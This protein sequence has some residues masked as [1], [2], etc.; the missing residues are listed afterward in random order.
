M[1]KYYLN[2]LGVNNSLGGNP[3]EVLQAL[4]DQLPGTAEEFSLVSGRKTMTRPVKVVLPEIPSGFIEF[5]SRN[6][7][8]LLHAIEQ[9]RPDIVK[10]KQQYG[11]A[12]V[13][14]VLGTSTSGVQETEQA[15]AQNP[16]GPQG[17]DFFYYKQE[18]SNPSD[19]LAKYLELTGLSYTIS[20]ACT[21]SAKAFIE[22]KRLMDAD[23]CDAVIVGG[24]DTLSRLTLYGFDSL[25][26]VSAQVTNPF[27]KNRQGIN[28]GEG[29]AIFI[30]SKEPGEV[31]FAGYGESSDAYHISSPDPDG[32]GAEKALRMALQK[33]QISAD[34]IGYINLH[35]TGT[36]KNDFMESHVTQRIFG[37]TVP[38]ST[39]KPFMGHTLGAAGAQEAA[40]CYLVLSSVNKEHRL[41]PLVW[42]ECAD[43]ELPQLNYVKKNDVL[44]TPYCMSNSYAFGGNN[45]SL[46]FK[47]VL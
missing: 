24:V 14:I 10:I 47:A 46:I 45:V 21:S 16:E 4:V 35:G 6:N 44:K 41:P 18:V 20:T 19:F 34:Q 26:S 36:P 38:V 15:F 13:A 28:I 42:D 27:S 43:P 9:I 29:A 25:D 8:L 31:E 7:R 23:L 12:R 1:T 39:T 5:E 33:A 32:V 40:V 2:C 30:L 37:S 3:K 17:D 11:A 22:A